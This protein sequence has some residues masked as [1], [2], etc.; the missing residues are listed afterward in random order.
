MASYRRCFIVVTVGLIAVMTLGGVVSAHKR[1]TRDARTIPHWVRYPFEF[2]LCGIA[3]GTRA[4]DRD[5]NNNIA[6]Y[7]LFLVHGNPTAVV[8]SDLNVITAAQQPPGIATFLSQAEPQGIPTWALAT[9]VQLDANHV[10][11]VY[12][13][14]G[15]TMGFVVDRLGFVDAIVVA[16]LESP[17]AKTQM[18]DPEHTIQLGDDLRKVLF[19]YGYPDAIE[20]GPIGGGEAGGGLAGGAGMPGMG[21]MPGTPGMG[22]APGGGGMGMSG[23]GALPPPPGF[24]G[25]MFQSPNRQGQ[26]TMV[27]SVN[28]HTTPPVIRDPRYV[29]QVLDRELRLGAT[30]SPTVQKTSYGTNTQKRFYQA[31]LGML[32]MPGMGGV[33]MGG[34]PSMPGIPGRGGAMPGMGAGAGMGGEGIPGGGAGVGGAAG[35]GPTGYRTFQLRYDESYNIIFTIRNNRVIRI[36]IWGDPDY[37]TD[38]QRSTMRTRY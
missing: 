36:Y 22:G 32:G 26:Y 1:I 12:L 4:V 34:G 18:G 15:F 25:S 10:E 3:L 35:A 23:G 2:Q 11:W 8:L 20:P 14:D 30:Q 9:A 37:F 7:T 31:G 38:E 28:Y 5:A 17:I 6:R 33:G 29:K 16:G 21:G 24:R 27:T 13:R 19:R